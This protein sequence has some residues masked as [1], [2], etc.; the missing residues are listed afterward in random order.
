M[1]NAEKKHKKTKILLMIMG[2]AVSTAALIIWILNKI[3]PI[4]YG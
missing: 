4:K 1:T 2:F 3:P